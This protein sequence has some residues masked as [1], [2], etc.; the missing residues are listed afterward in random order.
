MPARTLG[1]K[2]LARAAGIR[3]GSFRQYAPRPLRVRAGPASIDPAEA[4]TLPSISIVTPS[5]NQSAFIGRTIRSV[6]EQGYP[7]LEYVVRDGGSTDGT[8][9]VLREH[10]GLVSSWVSEPDGG[11]ADA[12]NRGHA[13]TSGEIMAWLNSDDLLLPGALAVV[14]RCFRDH[15]E[16]D[17]LYGNR[18]IIDAD[19]REVG[20][21]VLPPHGP[22]AMLWRDYIPQETMF[23][24][25]SLWDRIGSRVDDS[26]RFAMDWDLVVRFWRAGAR[27][28]RLRAFLGAFTTHDEQKSLAWRRD[29]GEPEFARVRSAI[30]ARERVAA[31]AGSAAYIGLSAGYWW[32][33]RLARRR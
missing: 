23:W 17:V 24:R 10:E 26:F 7:D 20:R 14:G 2:S 3:I 18:V 4:G 1:P 28:R 5:Y 11:Q 12:I 30:P 6:A 15:P 25:R 27:F 22:W 16:V 31:R 29:V 19:G 33:D 13:R 21:W 9:E 32:A 8:V